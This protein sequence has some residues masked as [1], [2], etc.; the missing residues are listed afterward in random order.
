MTR[1][2]SATAASSSPLQQVGRGERDMK[3]R[4]GVLARPLSSTA[5]LPGGCTL[6]HHTLVPAAPFSSSTTYQ[7]SQSVS[8]T[9][10]STPGRLQQRGWRGVAGEWA[11]LTA[12][13]RLICYCCMVDVAV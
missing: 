9:S 7:S 13:L 6:T 1:S 11:L 12:D 10:T 4:G 2:P 5:Q 8:F 3:R